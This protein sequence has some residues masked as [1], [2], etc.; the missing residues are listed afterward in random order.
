[1][2][3]RWGVWSAG[4]SLAAVAKKPRMP[5]RPD[6]GG[7]AALPS[8]VMLGWPNRPPEGATRVAEAVVSAGTATGERPRAEGRCAGWDP[9]WWVPV[10]RAPRGRSTGVRWND[11]L[12]GC[13]RAVAEGQGHAAWDGHRGTRQA[14][15]TSP[16]K[17]PHVGAG[18]GRARGRCCCV[19]GS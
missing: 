2:P 15:S 4:S 16:K 7:K 9:K 12:L 14:V 5:G 19:T 17:I 3:C 6:E 1:M 11:M 8:W 18:K 13:R 10:A